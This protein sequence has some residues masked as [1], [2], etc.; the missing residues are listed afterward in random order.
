MGNDNSFSNNPRLEVVTLD[1]TSYFAGPNKYNLS[2]YL[3]HKAGRTQR[4]LFSHQGMEN[5]TL[6]VLPWSPIR[7]QKLCPPYTASPTV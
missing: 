7:R 5:S 1:T 2:I 4:V 6:C 3:T